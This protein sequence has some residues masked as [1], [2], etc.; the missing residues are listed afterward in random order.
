MTKDVRNIALIENACYNISHDENYDFSQFVHFLLLYGG[1]RRII[2]A[3]F[4]TV[5]V[6]SLAAG[7]YN[8]I[9]QKRPAAA[10]LFY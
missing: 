9:K 10:G 1:L 4:L 8:L 3:V 2:R 5:A 6:I 7:R